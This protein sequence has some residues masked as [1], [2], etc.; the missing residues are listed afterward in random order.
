M[1]KKDL[2]KYATY[3]PIYFKVFEYL[4]TIILDIFTLEFVF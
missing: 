3:L 4:Q 2:D 1:K